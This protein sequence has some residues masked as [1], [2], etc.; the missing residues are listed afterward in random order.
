MQLTTIMA[1]LRHL[2]VYENRCVNAEFVELVFFNRDLDQWQNSI[3][4]VLGAPRK[5]QGQ[6]PTPGDLE[7][8]ARTGGIRIEQ[9]LFEKKV[10]NGIIIAKFWPWKDD[11][12]TTLR[13]AF[14]KD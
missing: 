10:E 7:L 5:I 3:S 1:A 9:T 12:H 14:L 2:S 8:T 4:T 11:V 13:M 6:D